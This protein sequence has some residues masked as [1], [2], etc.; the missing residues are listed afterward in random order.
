MTEIGCAKYH[1]MPWEIWDFFYK[2]VDQIQTENIR[3]RLAE[4]KTKGTEVLLDSF[5]YKPTLIAIKNGEQV[6]N[7]CCDSMKDAEVD[8]ESLYNAYIAGVKDE[9]NYLIGSSAKITDDEE[10]KEEE[11]VGEDPITLQYECANAM[12]DFI[13]TILGK[14]YKEVE[15]MFDIE[16]LADLGER[17]VDVLIEESE[18]FKEV[19]NTVYEME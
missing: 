18:E 11:E 15:K 8:A 1:K 16:T 9:F 13:V 2:V 4:N 3:I 7:V 10:E 14:P 19:F 5:R 6:S 17:L 12:E